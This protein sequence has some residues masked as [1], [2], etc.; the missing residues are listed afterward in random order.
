MAERPMPRIGRLTAA[1]VL[2]ALGSGAVDAFSFAAL[3]AVFASVMTGNLVLL[4][5]ATVRGHLTPATAS[6][7]AIAAYAAG[8]FGT[9]RRLRAREL[10]EPPRWSAR[11]PDAFATVPLVQAAVL[12]GWLGSSARPGPV[13]QGALLALSALA[14][15][16]QSAGVNTL[17]IA[18]AA[19]TY[20]TGTLTTLTTELATSGLPSTMRLRFTVLAAAL[21]GAGL[22]AILLTWA[23]PA[24]PALPLAATLTVALLVRRAP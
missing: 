23:R 8:V 9:A 10:R 19:T 2:L 5:L 13:T 12:A 4:G 18:G 16:V 22:D 7:I 11:V 20:L 6:A 3:G 14:M 15:G 1:V 21:A 17:P 24:A